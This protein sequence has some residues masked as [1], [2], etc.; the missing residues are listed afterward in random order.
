MAHEQSAATA[1]RGARLVGL[2]ALAFVA[3]AFGGL[4]GALAAGGGETR[5]FVGMVLGLLVTAGAAAVVCRL[6]SVPDTAATCTQSK[7]ETADTKE[8]T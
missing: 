5:R 7:A 8:S 3:P 2:S 4:I 6:F 1:P